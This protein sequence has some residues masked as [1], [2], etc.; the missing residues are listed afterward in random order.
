M[1]GMKE[2]GVVE[3]VLVRAK[4]GVTDEQ[5]LEAADG[6]QREVEHFPGYIGR[7]VLKSEDG[8]WLDIVDWVSLDD[9]L[10]AAEA[11]MQRPIAQTY[12]SLVE[13]ESLRT[14]HLAPVRVYEA[15]PTGA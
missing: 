11:I 12:L 2:T 9:A 3:V 1:T 6:L 13:T 10:R 4:P 14:L 15:S 5:I 8:Q 7:Q